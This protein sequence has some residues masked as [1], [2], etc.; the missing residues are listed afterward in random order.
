MNVFGEEVVTVEHHVG[1]IANL[2]ELENDFHGPRRALDCVVFPAHPLVTLEK[3]N[4][5]EEKKSRLCL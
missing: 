2:L 5:G 3:K 4:G 1:E